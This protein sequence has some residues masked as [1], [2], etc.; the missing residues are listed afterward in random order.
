MHFHYER[1]L[2]I[3]CLGLAASSP[4][5]SG[6]SSH[7]AALPWRLPQLQ[8]IGPRPCKNNKCTSAQYESE[9][10]I[11]RRDLSVRPFN[12]PS[13]K[14][15]SIILRDESKK[16]PFSWPKDVFRRQDSQRG[17]REVRA[18]PLGQQGG[19]GA[20]PRCRVVD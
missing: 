18:S 15:N 5:S 16:K 20:A 2:R 9:S 6:W 13:A 10:L 12:N 19:D 4:C 8:M 11:A 1:S 14:L 7:S 3:L 17:H